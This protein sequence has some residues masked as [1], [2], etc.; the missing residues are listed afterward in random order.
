MQ[1][2][3]REREGSLRNLTTM[4]QEGAEGATE[5]LTQSRKTAHRSYLRRALC[6][7]R[8]AKAI[9]TCGGIE[10][11][12]ES[13]R[14]GGGQQTIH[15]RQRDNVLTLLEEGRRAERD[16]PSNPIWWYAVA[17]EGGGTTE[18]PP[19]AARL[20]VKAAWNGFCAEQREW[21]MR[22]NK[23]I[24]SNFRARDGM[25]KEDKMRW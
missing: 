12:A 25:M 5:N 9:K 15:L 1:W 22:R 20:C 10:G 11:T 4:P 6:R 19:E 3:Y 2:R 8:V 14:R 18:V 17:R 21:A 7:K 13:N 23:R 16:R 24:S